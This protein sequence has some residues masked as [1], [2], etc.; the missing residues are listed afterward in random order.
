MGEIAE[1]GEPSAGLDFERLYRND[2]VRAVRLARL[3]T[4]SNDA[5]VGFRQTARERHIGSRPGSTMR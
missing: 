1:R 4:G 3:L 2:F 5:A